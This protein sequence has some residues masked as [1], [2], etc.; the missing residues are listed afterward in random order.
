MILLAV[1]VALSLRLAWHEVQQSRKT[2]AAESISEMIPSLPHV[3]R[4]YADFTRGLFEQDLTGAT[5]VMSPDARGEDVVAVVLA[6]TAAWDDSALAKE[7][8]RVAVFVDGAD[9]SGWFS[10]SYRHLSVDLLSTEVA[11]WEQTARALDAEVSWEVSRARYSTPEVK[12]EVGADVPFIA[13]GPGPLIERLTQVRALD[14]LADMRTTWRLVTILGPEDSG[15]ETFTSSPAL[16]DDATF[17]LWRNLYAAIPPDN[18]ANEG[19]RVTVHTGSD[20]TPDE[21]SLQIT[22]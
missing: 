11:L 3:E 1:V 17:D 8:S 10:T 9:W 19:V 13:E 20:T 7:G 5:V 2:R 18:W 14:G 4:G 21:F 16:P 6:V 12:R 15:L 22:S